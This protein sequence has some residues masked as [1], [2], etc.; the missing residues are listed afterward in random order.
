MHT[1]N[2]SGIEF[3]GDSSVVEVRVWKVRGSHFW[4]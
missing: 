2:D 1:R 3:Q 4:G